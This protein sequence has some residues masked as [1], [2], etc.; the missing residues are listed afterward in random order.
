MNGPD[1]KSLQS[2]LE[3]A[4]E[5]AIRQQRSVLAVARYAMPATDLAAIYGQVNHASFLRSQH[6]DLTLLGLGCSLHLSSSGGGAL[7]DIAERWAQLCEIQSTETPALL[8]G[9][10]RFD[11]CSPRSE[12]WQAFDDASFVLAEWLFIQREDSVSLSGQYVVEADSDVQ[13]MATQGLQRYTSWVRGVACA[14]NNHTPRIVK[15]ASTSQAHWQAMVER[16]LQR[17]ETGALEKTVLARHVDY[18]LQQPLDSAAII[19]QLCQSRQ[20]AHVFAIRRGDACFLGAT[21]ER[22]IRSDQGHLFTHALAGTTRRSLNAEQ[23]VLLGEALI[24]NAKE[25]DEHRL[26]VEHITRVLHAHACDV[27]YPEAPNLLK[28][29]SV[30]HLS[31]PVQASLPVGGNLLQ[32][33]ARLH[34]TPAVGGTPTAD[35]LGFI[36]QHEGFDRGWYAAP[37]G[38]ID[39]NGDGDLLVALRSALLRGKHCHLFAGCGIVQ[40]SSAALEWSEIDSKLLTMQQALGLTKQPSGNLT[41][42]SSEPSPTPNYLSA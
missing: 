33:A 19:K 38:W 5:Q 39:S 3:T 30:Q 27:Q 17:I 9:G 22:L 14:A 4:R 10:A 31:T 6:P 26:V 8:I 28:L 36:R 7:E 34:P 12:N 23:D 37:I 24:A 18:Q 21:P 35:A 15:R 16:L 29:K 20:A 42:S 40:G 1:R 32:L 25:R 11:S 13:A 41:S 2:V